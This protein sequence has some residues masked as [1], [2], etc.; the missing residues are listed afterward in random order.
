MTK[1]E[2]NVKQKLNITKVLTVFTGHVTQETFETL[3]L[4]GVTNDLGLAVY[5][6]AAPNQGGNYGLYIYLD[7][8][9]DDYESLP[10]DLVSL[11]NLAIENDCMILCLDSDGMEL[12]GFP[13]FEWKD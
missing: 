8:S 4:D 13:I 9:V 6:K 10:E 5:T 12:E 1:L 3:M 2:N 7:P 11:I